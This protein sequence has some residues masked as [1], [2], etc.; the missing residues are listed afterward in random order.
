M[1]GFVD[2]ETCSPRRRPGDFSR[3]LYAKQYER[4]TE[5]WDSD[6]GGILLNLWGG[7]ISMGRENFHPRDGDRARVRRRLPLRPLTSGL[8]AS[9]WAVQASIRIRRC[10]RFT[11]Y[12][13]DASAYLR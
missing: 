2:I 11:L 3:Y 12:E 13:R 10:A 6:P 4:D 5:A 1:V 7:F 9:S 8:A